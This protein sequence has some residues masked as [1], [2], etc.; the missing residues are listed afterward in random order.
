MLR[1]ILLGISPYSNVF[2]S[3]HS[4]L[5]WSVTW[6][7]CLEIECDKKTHIQKVS[8]FLEGDI[9]VFSWISHTWSMVIFIPHSSETSLMKAE[10]KASSNSTV[11]PGRAHILESA[12]LMSTN[13]LSWVVISPNTPPSE[14]CVDYSCFVFSKFVIGYSLIYLRYSCFWIFFY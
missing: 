13:L 9:M 6:G 3:R 2:I 4:S 8:V 14:G 10:S 1:S 11:P 5:A 12:L 7:S